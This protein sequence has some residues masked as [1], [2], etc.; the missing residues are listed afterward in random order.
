[1]D[2]QTFVAGERVKVVQSKF[3]LQAVLLV[4]LVVLVA[5]QVVLSSYGLY[6]EMRREQARAELMTSISQFTLI[7]S[8]IS[9]KLLDD[10]NK[11]VYHNIDVDSVLKQQVV[12][13]DYLIGY[14]KLIAKQNNQLLAAIGEMR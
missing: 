5:V 12:G 8:D 10:Y 2:D 11:N 4:V 1:M 6:R 13:N 9:D 3:S 7:N 14:L